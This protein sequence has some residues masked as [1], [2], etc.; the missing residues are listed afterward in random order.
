VPSLSTFCFIFKCLERAADTIPASSCPPFALPSTT[1]SSLKPDSPNYHQFIHSCMVFTKRWPLTPWPVPPDICMV[2]S[3][4][5]M[6]ISCLHFPQS[7]S[8]SAHTWS[9]ASGWQLQ[10][11][12]LSYFSLS[13][14]LSLSLFVSVSTSLSLSLSLHC[15]YFHALQSYSAS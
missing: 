12:P 10:A 13:L 14:S 9:W 7:F 6:G 3:S 1:A 2:W 5:W 4:S 11:F 8:T 15:T